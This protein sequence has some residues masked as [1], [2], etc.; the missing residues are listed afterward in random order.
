M[1][2][3]NHVDVIQ[4]GSRCLVSDIYRVLQGQ[5]PYGEGLKLGIAG[6]CAP[7]V[8]VVQ[9]AETYCHLAAARARGRHDD[10][11]AGSLHIVVLAKALVTGY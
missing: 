6:T 5:A 10:Q 9:L 1:E 7:A 4:V 3:V 8:F 11:L 2:R